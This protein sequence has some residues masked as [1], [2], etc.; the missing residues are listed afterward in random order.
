MFSYTIC[1]IV[2]LGAVV[3]AEPVA[4]EAAEDQRTLEQPLCHFIRSAASHAELERA[5]GPPTEQ[6]EIISALQFDSRTALLAEKPS[7]AAS[8][9]SLADRKLFESLLVN[10][11]FFED[12]A[13]KQRAL[14]IGLLTRC[15]IAGGRPSLAA[16]VF[17]QFNASQRATFVCITHALLNS[18]LVDSHDG[19]DLGDALQMI[20]ELFE[21]QGENSALPSD[22]QFQLIVRLTPDASGKLERAAHF[23]KGENHIFHKDYPVSFR[24]FR[25]IGLHG[26]EAGLHICLTRDG[27]FAQ[28]HIDYRFGLLHLGPANSD[29]RANGNHQRHV[30]RW[31]EFAVAVKRVEVLHV[32]L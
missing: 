11:L 4:S 22:H 17:G 13:P 7:L 2:L 28:I 6:A 14:L 27:R 5:A 25:K 21:I 32:V 12:L 31:P 20:E 24:Q 8:S 9:N 23:L 30:A 18:H 26:Q 16:S 15:R 3:L 29:V 19:K 1:L 10:W